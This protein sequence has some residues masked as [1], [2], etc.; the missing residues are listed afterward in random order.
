MLLGSAANLRQHNRLDG[1]SDIVVLAVHRLHRGGV[2]LLGSRGDLTLAIIL[3]WL[4]DICVW[5]RLPGDG[6]EG[7]EEEQTYD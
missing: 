5:R 1:L 7:V 3:L 4:L 2:L 6:Y